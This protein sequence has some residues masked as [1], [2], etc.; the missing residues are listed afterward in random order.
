MP[1]S[2]PWPIIESAAETG[3]DASSVIADTALNRTD[4]LPS[5]KF[6]RLI[7][8]LFASEGNET[9]AKGAFP[10]GFFS[11]IPTTLSRVENEKSDRIIPD[12][13]ESVAVHRADLPKDNRPIECPT[14]S[15][16][17]QERS[18]AP[19]GGVPEQAGAHKG[20]ESASPLTAERIANA[21]LA[22]TDFARE[23]TRYSDILDLAATSITQ[24]I[25]YEEWTVPAEM[26]RA[27][28]DHLCALGYQLVLQ[29]ECDDEA[30]FRD[31]REAGDV[32]ADGEP[33]GYDRYYGV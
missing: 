28:E 3:R 13:D 1:V 18:E 15:R 14:D 29:R 11:K 9:I 23:L 5:I 27:A 21:A 10:P 30:A 32:D 20:S 12:C 33:R 22:L 7:N 19:R 17:D 25:D 16:R 31:A 6:A 24:I 4:N 26:R 8:P 2:H